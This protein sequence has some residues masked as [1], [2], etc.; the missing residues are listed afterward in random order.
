MFERNSWRCCMEKNNVKKI[1][2][3]IILWTIGTLWNAF[4]FPIG[5]F[6]GDWI[7]LGRWIVC[8]GDIFYLVSFSLILSII[9]R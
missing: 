9:W 5:G 3:G 8:I 6:W 7:I 1:I 2:C 4:L